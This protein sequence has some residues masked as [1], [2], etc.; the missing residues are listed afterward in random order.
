MP[1]DPAEDLRD[2][3]LSLPSSGIV[4]SDRSTEPEIS[5]PKLRITVPEGIHDDWTHRCSQHGPPWIDGRWQGV[6]S[7][8]SYEVVLR[9]IVRPGPAV[10]MQARVWTGQCP[11]CGTIYWDVRHERM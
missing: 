9:M 1:K 11:D 2:Y 8:V 10:G 7:P 5:Y 3:A 6:R 4:L